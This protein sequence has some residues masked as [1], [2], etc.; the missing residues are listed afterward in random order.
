[1]CGI[2][3]AL[4]DQDSALVPA[5][6]EALRH[7]GPDATG[8]Y[9]GAVL[10]MGSRR[11]SVI[12]LDGGTQPL[13]D[14]TG[15]ICVVANG[16]I[17]NHRA[18]RTELR[19]RGHRFATESDVEVIVH[20]YEEHG[21]R[22]AEH[23]QGMFAF[24]VADGEKLLL[25]RDR[26]G[27]KPLYYAIVPGAFLFASEIKA[28]LR[29]PGLRPALDHEAFV[30]AVALG[31]PVGDRT[32]FSGVATL[33]PGTSLRVTLGERGVET[34]RTRYYALPTAEPAPIPFEEATRHLARLLRE[35]VRAHL[36]SD[37]EVGLLLSGGL[38]STVL[39]ML[40]REEYGRPFRA[41]SVTGPVPHA[42]AVQAA[43]LAEWLGCEH[44]VLRLG[45]AD[46]VDAIPGYLRTLEQAVFLTGGIP[47]Y[48]LCERIGGTPKVCLAGEG[49]DELFGGYP[50]YVNRSGTPQIHADRL[51][52]LAAQGLRPSDRAQEIIDGFSAD[53]PLAGYLRHTFSSNLRDQLVRLHLEPLDALSMAFGVEMRVPYVDHRLTEFVLSL[54]VEFRVNHELGIPKHIL[55]HAALTLCGGQGPV[56]DS[57]LRP[58]IGAPSAGR[59]HARAFER[60]C[61][62]VLPEDYLTRHEWGWAF[63][64]KRQLLLFELFWELFMV[65]RGEPVDGLSMSEFIS[66]RAEKPLATVA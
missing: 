46:Y 42:D 31:Y 66:A 25:V 60:L 56:V 12:D 35:T 5:M 59:A 44:E 4:G 45:L 40:M 29:H 24:A 33:P 1:M 52:R 32:L 50:E 2:A 49:A 26:L 21:D 10:R 62:R 27:V 19:A 41:F 61:Q 22:C 17:F 8:D 53:R 64:H 54:P 34:R 16:E 3:G 36:E 20:L 58:K 28:L 14:E 63:R 37:V 39:G 11:L 18:L 13:Y 57:V 65:N 47:L 15:G 55:K 6:T 30:D 38:D 23:L 48:A 7:R 9:S 51:R 43:R